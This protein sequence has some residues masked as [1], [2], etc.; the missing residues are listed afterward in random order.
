MAL[1][2]SEAG[3]ATSNTSSST[4]VVTPTVSFSANDGV[5][6][7]IAADNSTAQ[8]GLPFSSVT[9]SQSNTYTL[10]RSVKQQGASQNN[11]ACGAIYFC[12]VQNALSVSD[13][14]TVNFLNNTTAKAA[15]TFKIGAAANKK[16]SQISDNVFSPTGDASS[17]SRS[18]TTMTSGDAL[19]YFLA[20]E[21]NGVVTGDSDTTRGSWSSAYVA[22]ADSGTALTSMQA[23]SQYKI[24]TGNGTQTWDT[25]FPSSSS[26]A[27]AYATFREVAALSTF[28]RTATGSGAG[29]AT[30]ATK[31]T[32]LRLGIHTDFSFGF[33][34]GAGRFYIGPPT[35]VRTATG[36]GTGAGSATKKIVAV[37]TATGSGTGTSSSAEILIAKRTATAT[38][39]GTSTAATK[40]SRTRLGYLID[41]HTGFYGNGGRFYLG[42]PIIA[43]T[44][45]GAGQGTQTATPLPIKVRTATGT[46]T[47]TSNNT[48]V[49]G[50]LRT[51][52]GSGGATAGDQALI[53]VARVRTATGSGT[54]GSSISYIELLP[55]TATGTGQGTATTTILRV[56]PRTA[57]GGSTSGSV[58][59]EILIAIRTATGSGTGTAQAIGARIRRRT[60]T[61]TGT[62]DGS[63]DWTKSHIFRVPY[64]ETY[65]GGY[66]GGGDAANRLQR[67]NR[68]NVR[69]LNLYKLTDGSYTTITQRDLGQVAKIW[70]GGR[71]HF[72]TDAEVVELTEAG[73]GAS[74]T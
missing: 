26:F 34:N 41:Y 20:I 57:T 37:R 1:T 39:T 25:T 13:S 54:G 21:N 61:A 51:G 69:G 44:A 32:Q 53:L 6:V 49:V 12:V 33:I 40:A 36:S 15:V 59:I 47:G 62:G 64:T 28:D 48:I 45:T 17:S 74:I 9:D 42:A 31:V 35:I 8:G 22:N 63:A 58:T 67:Y 14:I 19:V 5:V 24:V 2:I 30:A 16:P 71:D 46:G 10:V 70:Y 43:R 73:F 50:R 29:T 4:L 3:S 11:L 18:T 23:F 68:T 56:V 52:Y 65:P 72:L 66:F 7:C 27:T 60:G 55:R 38:S